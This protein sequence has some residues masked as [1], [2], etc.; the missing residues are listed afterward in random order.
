MLLRLH[1]AFGDRA[2]ALGDEQRAVAT[3]H[4]PAA[5][6][7]R[8]NS[9]T[10]PGDRSP[11]RS[12]TCGAA[13][14]TNLPRATAVLFVPLV[15]RLGVAPVDQ[16]VLR[17]ARV[18]RDVEQAAL[19]AG[20]DRRQPGD[21]LRQLPSVPTTRSRPGRSVTSILPPGRN[22]MP[23]GF[24]SPSATVTTSNATFDALHGRS[25]LP[26]KGRAL[27]RRVRRSGVGAA[28]RGPRG[29][30][31]GTGGNE[32]KECDEGPDAH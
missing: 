23:H 19:A 21:R 12:S 25:G 32:R 26:R 22:A 6:V 1:A 27:I 8:S 24:S 5:E 4:Q 31:A 16:L 3:E 15:A 14:S 29:L 17:E 11:A 30:R 7:Q 2:L 18:E 9:A 20:V 10:A 28:L 13:P